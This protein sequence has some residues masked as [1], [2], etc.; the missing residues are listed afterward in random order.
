MGTRA[1]SKDDASLFFLGFRPWGF[2]GGG[3]EERTTDDRESQG[4]EASGSEHGGV[5]MDFCFIYLSPWVT[6]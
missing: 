1:A 3:G 6:V 4:I 2:G 5:W